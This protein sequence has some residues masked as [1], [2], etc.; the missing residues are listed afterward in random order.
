MLRNQRGDP[1]EVIR[2]TVQV[3]VGILGWTAPFLDG[4]PRDHGDISNTARPRTKARFPV[5]VASCKRLL[6][7]STPTLG[8]AIEAHTDERLLGKQEAVSSIL[9]DGSTGITNKHSLV[10]T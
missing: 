6:V 8:P 3:E 7:G 4:W 5:T 10:E 9:T 1:L 2:S